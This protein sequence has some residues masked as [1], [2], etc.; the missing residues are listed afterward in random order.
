MSCSKEALHV[1]GNIVGMPDQTIYLRVYESSL[2]TIDSTKSEGGVF[3][4]E[5]PNILP[6]I[7]YI[8]LGETDYLIPLLVDVG[9]VSIGGNFNYPDEIEVGG[10][11]ANNALSQFRN[12]VRKYDIM[13]KAIDIDIARLQTT[14][15]DT[16]Q[17]KQ[18]TAK[19][20]VL[21]AQHDNSRTEFV[22]ANRGSLVSALLILSAV[23]DSTNRHQIDSLI[24]ELEPTMADN[25]FLRRLQRKRNSTAQ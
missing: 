24:G 3:Q 21:Q 10:T 15:D 20:A 7:V 25:A 22:R 14:K 12:M 4:F 11:P 16:L 8:Q 5:M 1:H 9:E 17:I 13:L 2:R 18:L 23:T 19:R 6:N